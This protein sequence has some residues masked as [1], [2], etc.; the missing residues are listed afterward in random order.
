MVVT[1]KVSRARGSPTPSLSLPQSSESRSCL[2]SVRS[3]C[4]PSRSCVS[5]SQ[6][7]SSPH[8]IHIRRLIVFGFVA[9]SFSY[10]L[11]S[12]LSLLRSSPLSLSQSVIA[13]FVAVTVV[14]CVTPLSGPQS[15]SSRSRSWQGEMDLG[16]VGSE[17]MGG[18]GRRT[19]EGQA[20]EGK[21]SLYR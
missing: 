14:T 17:E 1:N 13:F 11:R 18:R 21:L 5:P 6:P 3:C 19:T 2:A 8:C 4:L 10:S 9:S 20:E 16:D 15:L 7:L 12:S